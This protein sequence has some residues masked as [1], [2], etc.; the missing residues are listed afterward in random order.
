MKL[1]IG[2]FKP[3]TCACSTLSKLIV[4]HYTIKAGTACS[5]MAYFNSCLPYSALFFFSFPFATSSPL[6]LPS[7]PFAH[8]TIFWFSRNS[9]YLCHSLRGLRHCLRRQQVSGAFLVRPLSE[10]LSF[11]SPQALSALSSALL[12]PHVGWVLGCL[13]GASLSG[14]ARYVTYSS[15]S[16]TFLTF[17]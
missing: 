16:I 9:L 5:P 10:R 17:V 15:T 6:L 12:L 13:K 7:A 8:H 14:I 2:R 4:Y 1:H 11:T 3:S